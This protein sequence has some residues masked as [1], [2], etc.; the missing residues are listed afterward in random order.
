MEKYN[1]IKS[2]KNP[3]VTFLGYRKYIKIESIAKNFKLSRDSNRNIIAQTFL[4]RK[5]PIIEEK[6]SNI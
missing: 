2:P 4:K 3:K 6:I 1:G 5:F